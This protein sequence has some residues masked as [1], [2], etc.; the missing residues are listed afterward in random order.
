MRCRI[1][2]CTQFCLSCVFVDIS[3]KLMILDLIGRFSDAPALV[4]FNVRFWTSNEG[5]LSFCASLLVMGNSCGPGYPSGI[6]L[7]VAVSLSV[8]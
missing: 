5:L 2:R 8:V 6:A 4:G 7:S 1:A 3:G